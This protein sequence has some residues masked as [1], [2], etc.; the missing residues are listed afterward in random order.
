MTKG[1]IVGHLRNYLRV[2]KK[3]AASI[4]DKFA[5]LAMTET[6]NEEGI[7]HFSIKEMIEQI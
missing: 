4:I 6:K 5:A 2:S 1:Q 3:T 7:V